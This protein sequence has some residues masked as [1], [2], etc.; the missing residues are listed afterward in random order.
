MAKNTLRIGKFTALFLGLLMF[1]TG[2]AFAKS[3]DEVSVTV[4]GVAF[5]MLPTPAA[6]GV[7]Y[8][9]KGD[10]STLFWSHGNEATLTVGG[11]EYSRY[12]LVQEGLE[13]DELFLTVDGKIYVMR[14]VE[15]ASGEKYEAENDPT[16]VFWGKG[17]S[18]MLTVEGKRYKGYDHFFPFGEIWTEDRGI[19]LEAEWKVTSLDGADLVEGSVITAVFHADGTLNGKASINNYNASW[20]VLR[21]RVVISKGVSTRMAGKPALMEQ[22]RVFLELLSAASRFASWGDTLVL[23]AGDGRELTLKK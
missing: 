5:V 15:A 13:E 3:K 1:A 10:P 7:K 4:E 23:T 14:R 11:R 12:V 19:P 17:D 8:E 6:S 9:A 22:E 18:A 20:M 21:D 16:T 2:G